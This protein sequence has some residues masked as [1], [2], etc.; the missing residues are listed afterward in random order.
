MEGTELRQCSR[1]VGGVAVRWT[2]RQNRGT[3]PAGVAALRASSRGLPSARSPRPAP[4]GQ[5]R[6]WGHR[7]RGR[8]GVVARSARAERETDALLKDIGGT[9]I[10][11]VGMMGSG[12][13]TVG[14]LLAE[15]LQYRF[16]DTDDVIEKSL[17]ASV[18]QIFEENGEEVFR[19]VEARV[20]QELS[21]YARSVISTGGGAVLSRE[22]W[23]NMR[24]GIVVWLNGKPETLASRI[25]GQEKDNRPLLS[26]VGEESEEELVGR[27]SG[28][29]EDR[30][31]FY[32]EAD[33]VVPLEDGQTGEIF[34][35]EKMMGDILEMLAKAVQDKKKEVEEKKDFTVEGLP[36]SMEVREPY[37]AGGDKG[38]PKGFGAKE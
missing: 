23:G 24:H 11:L 1:R 20:L 31:K 19:D 13:S 29:L 16:F 22:N 4:L 5:G 33:I 8:P 28:I 3:G 26:D 34:A 7:L 15:Q 18:S 2:G 25:K 21:Q 27:M 35:P 14:K 12:K 36:D 37:A 6:R 32:E 17:G 38:A 9:A 30:Q 10:Y